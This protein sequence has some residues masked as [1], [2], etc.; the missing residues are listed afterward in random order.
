MTIISIEVDSIDLLNDIPPEDVARHY[1]TDICD[2]L[3]RND[4][5]E[6]LG[7]LSDLAE[8]LDTD[9][10]DALFMDRHPNP[11]EVLDY[12][13]DEAIMDYL[14]NKGYNVEM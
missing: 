5:I 2:W 13:D 14:V 4:L 8:E 7:G 3:H 1:G 12:I 10:I 6:Y 11:S 9:Q